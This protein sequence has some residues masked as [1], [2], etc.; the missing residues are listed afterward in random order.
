MK[1]K[2]PLDMIYANKPTSKLSVLNALESCVTIL[3]II[4][5]AYEHI[6]DTVTLLKFIEMGVEFAAITMVV[7]N[8]TITRSSLKNVSSYSYDNTLVKDQTFWSIVIDI[9]Y[10]TLSAINISAAPFMAFLIMT[11]CLFSIY[12]YAS[13]LFEVYNDKS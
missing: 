13:I 8:N 12:E 6:G 4:L 2:T 1:T 3:M 9:L 7:I 5:L 10:I 11:I